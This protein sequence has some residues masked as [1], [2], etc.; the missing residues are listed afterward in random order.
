MAQSF[1]IGDIV[2]LKSGSPKM[3]V[4]GPKMITPFD[5]SPYPHASEVVCV[6]FNDKHE[7]KVH[8]FEQDMLEKD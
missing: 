5:G 6:F 2:R 3:T 7:E 8:V 4:K 1:K